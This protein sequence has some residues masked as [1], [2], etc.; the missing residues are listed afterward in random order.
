M[1][2]ALLLMV[3]DVLLY[4]ETRARSSGAVLHPSRI[5]RFPVVRLTC[6]FALPGSPV[7]L[8]TDKLIRVLANGRLSCMTETS[9]F[10]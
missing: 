5:T 2:A 1:A 9:Y 4:H 7:L 10:F 8:W 3:G 6:V